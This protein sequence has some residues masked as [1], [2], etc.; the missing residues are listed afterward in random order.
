MLN[1]YLQNAYYQTDNPDHPYHP[2]LEQQFAKDLSG[3]TIQTRPNWARKVHKLINDMGLKKRRHVKLVFY[4]PEKISI[5]T[6]FTFYVSCTFCIF[7]KLHIL[8]IL[9]TLHT[10]HILHN[11]TRI[12]ISFPKSFNI[13]GLTV[14]VFVFVFVFLFSNSLCHHL[15]LLLVS[16]FVFVCI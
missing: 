8:H 7:C 11:Q 12:V 15:L 9:H 16:V 14:V 6:F 5:N 1:I 10:L 2:N 4:I 3:T 13:I